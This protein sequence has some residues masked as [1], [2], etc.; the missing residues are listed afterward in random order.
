M[1]KI[2][3]LNM[4]VRIPS[5]PRTIL[6]RYNALLHAAAPALGP[7]GEA[8]TGAVLQ[9]VK[10]LGLGRRLGE[11]SGKGGGF[12]LAMPVIFVPYYSERW[13]S[14]SSLH[15]SYRSLRFSWPIEKCMFSLSSTQ[16]KIKSGDEPN[17]TLSYGHYV[18]YPPST[19]YAYSYLHM[20]DAK[21]Q[22]Q[23]SRR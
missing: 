17:H 12:D 19:L 15:S 2:Y 11:V 5:P 21:N 4:H 18:P 3:Q 8:V 13:S 6:V 9:L 1:I 10:D 14:T 22:P 20:E 16:K 23:S 7:R